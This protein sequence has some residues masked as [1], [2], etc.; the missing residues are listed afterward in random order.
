MT[1]VP[2]K[3][4]L[5]PTMG[6]LERDGLN[7][8][9]DKEAENISLYLPWLSA[10]V[11]VRYG[12]TTLLRLIDAEGSRKISLAKLSHYI[13]IDASLTKVIDIYTDCAD[14]VDIQSVSGFIESL[15]KYCVAQLIQQQKPSLEIIKC[16]GVSLRTVQRCLSSS[17]KKAA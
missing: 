14:Y 10:E 6:S 1:Y 4:F 12:A 17:R 11:L 13:E 9:L 15:R 16:T 2:Y 5:L 7:T 3:L 8:F